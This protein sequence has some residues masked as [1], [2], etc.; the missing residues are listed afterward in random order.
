MKRM[1]GTFVFLG[2]FMGL[3]WVLGMGCGQ[4]PFAEDSNP[5]ER[6]V[7]RYERTH[8]FG[9]CPVFRAAFF[10]DGTAQLEVIRPFPDGPLIKLSPGR[11]RGLWVLPDRSAVLDIADDLQ[12]GGLASEYDNPRVM[13]VPSV[14]TEINGHVVRNRFGG[15]DLAKL[16]GALDH[17]LEVVPWEAVVASE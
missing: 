7:G 3:G 15:P 13:D 6:S 10:P 4:R 5:M 2:S 12:Y 1:A 14:I 17:W 16:Y 11:Y 8:C 9:P